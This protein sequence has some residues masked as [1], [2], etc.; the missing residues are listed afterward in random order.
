MNAWKARRQLWYWAFTA[1]SMF[2]ISPPGTGLDCFRTWEA[3]ALGAIP[4]KMR[5]T[6][7]RT[8]A[9]LPVLLVDSMRD[10]N[11]SMLHARY[12]EFQLRAEKFDFTRL[13]AE[14]WRDM[15]MHVVKTGSSEI[16]QRNH[17]I[18]AHY[19]GGVRALVA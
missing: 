10:V 11:A 18:P 7:D 13:T 1:D 4:I 6:F 19:G 3:L 15:V 17:P 14:Y 9:K 8:F 5:S 2:V 12:L 16:V